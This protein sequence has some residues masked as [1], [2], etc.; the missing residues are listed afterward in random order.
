MS[1]IASISLPKSWVFNRMQQKVMSHANICS[2]SSRR[3]FLTTDRFLL[4]TQKLLFATN[5]Q[6]IPE[7]YLRDMNKRKTIELFHIAVL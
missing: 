2:L 5:I 6:D 3:G 1:D 4:L 7:M